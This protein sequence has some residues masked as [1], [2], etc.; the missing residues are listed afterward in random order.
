VPVLG[1]Y[2]WCT[3][4]FIVQRVLG[5]RSVAHARGG[6]LLAGLLKLPVLFIMVLPGVMA[7]QILPPLENGDQVFP[8]L[9]AELCPR[10]S[11]G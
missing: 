11:P 3:N 8:A 6:V 2:F 9:I 1:F 5:A 4:Q 7:V 10:G